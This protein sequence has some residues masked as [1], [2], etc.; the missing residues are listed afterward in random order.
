MINFIVDALHDAG[1]SCIVTASSGVAALELHGGRTAHSAFGIPVD[2]L[3]EKTCCNVK[4]QTKHGRALVDTDLF[5]L[6]EAPMMDRFALEA[7]DRMLQ[8]NTACVLLRQELRDIIM[9][10]AG[11]D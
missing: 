5:V 3:D 4:K 1:R 11:F 7:I 10:D 9:C 6:D 8:V 2:V